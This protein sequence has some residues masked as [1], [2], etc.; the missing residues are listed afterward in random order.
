MTSKISRNNFY[1]EFI[2][3][4]VFI[5]D[6]IILGFSGVMVQDRVVRTYPI[7]YCEL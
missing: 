6:D 7:H 3:K 2:I 4:L 5:N 1:F